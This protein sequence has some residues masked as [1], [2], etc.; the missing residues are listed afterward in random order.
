MTRD[1]SW[2][3]Q[4]QRRLEDPQVVCR[5]RERRP[6]DRTVGCHNGTNMTLMGGSSRTRTRLSTSVTALLLGL[7]GTTVAPTARA[8]VNVA[9]TVAAVRI[10]ASNESIARILSVLA[11][12][13]GVRYST[14]IALDEI[15][16]GTYSGSL[17]EAI[18]S[19]LSGCGCNYVIRH[20][21]G[22]VEIVVLGKA[23][24]EPV[25]AARSAVPAPT[26]A[27]QWR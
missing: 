1:F 22:A 5:A 23:G 14:S 26:F 16:S 13:F 9:G 2:Q 8:E 15:V 17:S 7:L 12:T 6:S 24:A 11:K 3:A 10:G 25:A 19:L 18:S 4:E 20:D 27:A 21:H